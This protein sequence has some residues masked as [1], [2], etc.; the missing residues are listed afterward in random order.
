MLSI[1]AFKRL[2]TDMPYSTLVMEITQT[3]GE[4]AQREAEDTVE[5]KKSYFVAQGAGMS[6]LFCAYIV[7]TDAMK[8]LF[9]D[10][11]HLGWTLLLAA[12]AVALFCLLARSCE[13]LQRRLQIKV[14][15]GCQ[16]VFTVVA[17]APIIFF[18]KTALGLAATLT[19]QCLAQANY[20]FG[21]GA[22]VFTSGFYGMG[23]TRAFISGLPISLLT[24]YC[25]QFFARSMSSQPQMHICMS[26]IVGFCF[27]AVAYTLHN[28]ISAT[29]YYS[30][31]VQLE[32]IF[33]LEEVTDDSLTNINFRVSK[34]FVLSMVAAFNFFVLYPRVALMLMPAAVSETVWTTVVLLLGVGLY[35]FGA[36]KRI[37][38]IEKDWVQTVVVVISSLQSLFIVAVYSGAMRLGGFTDGF[39]IYS[40]LATA[41]ICLQTGFSVSLMLLNTVFLSRSRS[42]SFFV[43]AGLF[44]GILFGHAFSHCVDQETVR[45]QH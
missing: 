43:N 37:R 7:S 40:L 26:L 39:K 14:S 21:H 1:A 41:A 2:E 29:D 35:L 33:K 45:S 8:K 5:V 30:K 13:V 32:R 23:C 3:D 20:I 19:L 9:P 31:N 28:S 16:A 38:P 10:Y 42:A 44:V 4:V 11:G 34:Y 27:V 17:A 22:V 6:S 36:A 12:L 15:L 25:I 24:Q 18:P